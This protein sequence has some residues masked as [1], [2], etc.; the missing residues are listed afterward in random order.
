MTCSRASS[1]WLIVLAA[2]GAALPAAAVP[3]RADEP[4]G[5]GASR[6]AFDTLTVEQCIA[7]ARTQ[8]AAVQSAAADAEA[9]RLESV[10]AG[11]NRR[12]SWSVLGDLIVAPKG[13]YDPVLTNLGEYQLKAGAE[14]P[15]FD[16]GNR[17]RD[18]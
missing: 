5:P 15:L 12:P 8:G 17:R 9:A 3:A 18:R 1:F 4:Q 11:Y 2:A 6:A 10:V 13:S 7:L 16:A 14:W